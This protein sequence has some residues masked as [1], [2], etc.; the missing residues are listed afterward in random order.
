MLL[1]PAELHLRR[2]CLFTNVIKSGR[3]SE[4]SANLKSKF[5]SII[6]DKLFTTLQHLHSA[7]LKILPAQSIIKSFAQTY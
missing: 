5:D 6:N 1:K 4:R 2:G 3:T 7:L